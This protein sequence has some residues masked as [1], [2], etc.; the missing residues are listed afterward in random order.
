MRI[1]A[2]VIAALVFS[3]SLQAQHSSALQHPADDHTGAFRCGT[4]PDIEEV[5]AA[6]HNWAV[7][8]AALM[9]Q[10]AATASA[11][12]SVRLDRGIIV[13][14]TNPVTALFDRPFDLENRTVTLTRAADAGYSASVG[15]LEYDTDAG[16]LFHRFENTGESDWHYRPYTISGFNF[17]FGSRSVGEIF[18]SAH[19]HL[20]VE[21][22][23]SAGFDQFHLL[24]ALSVD[25]PVIAPLAQT[26]ASPARNLVPPEVFIKETGDAL[27]ITWRTPQPSYFAVDL[28]LKVTSAGDLTFSYR[29]VERAAW[30]TLLVSTGEEPWR[31]SRAAIGSFGDT[32]GDVDSRSPSSLLEMLD[33][34]SVTLERI[35]ETGLLEARIRT[36]G[37]IDR[38][39]LD[40]PIFV[41]LLM[42]E[43][44]GEIRDRYSVDI[45]A[46]G[47]DFVRNSAVYSRG[48]N[49]VAIEG[50]VIVVRMLQ[51]ELLTVGPDLWLGVLIRPA[52][53]P[54]N[55]D[56]ASGILTLGAPTGASSLRFS[57]L[58]SPVRVTGPLV[59]T[60]TLPAVNTEGV[61]EQL[62]SAYPID[63]SSLDGVA[64][65]QDH[66]SDI[67]FYAGA[68]ATRGNPGVDGISP[69]GGTAVP[70]A[71]TIMHMNLYDY[72]WNARPEISGSVLNHEFGHRWLYFFSIMEDGV[73]S[74]RLNPF[75]AHPAQY[76]HTAAAFPVV[77]PGDASTMGGS[78]FKVNG[79]GTF[80]TP[81]VVGYFGYSWHELYL[82]GLASPEEVPPWFYIA[83]TDPALGLQ[84]TPPPGTTVSGT[85][86]D[87][88]IDQVIESMG[89]RRPSAAE[90]QRHFRVLFVL[91]TRPGSEP[92]PEIIDA[93]VQHRLGFESVFNR[94]TGGRGHV[95]TSF[96]G[97]AR[98]RGAGPVR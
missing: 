29:N 42:G 5:A 86:R 77:G 48:S 16:D 1:T 61:F 46:S 55:A 56:V 31:N 85:K 39:Q 59:E 73:R 74:Q 47:L 53:Q 25:H 40:V 68:Y 90:S 43:A 41:D 91:L 66:P 81:D 69:V 87:V 82:M 17:P 34:V 33:V 80:S 15:P 75:G 11:G 62:R 71:P 79:D 50:D 24:E 52:S 8:R 27:T 20:G 10:I 9:P 45:R 78:N 13:M 96:G 83:D 6:R 65:Y 32:S 28:Q 2:L 19:H 64:I 49:A 22:P 70:R 44:V 67:I 88:V 36:R 97:G 21:S 23:M 12:A 35:G 76:V 95:S 72:G 89:P 54:F 30:G 26:L 14:E 63:P 37:E 4:V 57:T 60:F 3:S 58:A 7:E 51:D 93:M 92:S 84:Y 18:I 98:R 94:A 38:A